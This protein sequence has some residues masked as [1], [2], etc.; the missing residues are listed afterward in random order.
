MDGPTSPQ[1]NTTTTYPPLE[2]K[3]YLE[4]DVGTLRGTPIT[5]PGDNPNLSQPSANTQYQR[6]VNHTGL[7]ISLD[8]HVV[9]PTTTTVHQ[10]TS[11][12]TEI[13]TAIPL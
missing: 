13:S 3:E 10:Q 2:I 7:L 8:G 1:T 5:N 9:T 11:Q 4:M 6:K 12:L